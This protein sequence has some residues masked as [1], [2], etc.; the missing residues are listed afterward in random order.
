MEI[1]RS[2]SLVTLMIVLFKISKSKEGPKVLN[3][4]SSGNSVVFFNSLF[5]LLLGVYCRFFFLEVAKPIVILAIVISI[6]SI[7]LLS[8]G[9]GLPIPKCRGKGV[10]K[11]GFAMNMEPGRVL[12]TAATQPIVISSFKILAP[13]ENVNIMLSTPWP[14]GSL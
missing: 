1:N 8:G 5:S 9:C 13:T 2:A 10:V 11:D 7:G 6:M 4:N 14:P 3:T 12:K